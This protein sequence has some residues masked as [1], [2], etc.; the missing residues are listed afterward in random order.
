M[1]NNSKKRER[2][3]QWIQYMQTNNSSLEKFKRA[4]GA[5]ML[6]DISKPHKILTIH[7]ELQINEGHSKNPYYRK[8]DTSAVLFVPLLPGHCVIG[9]FGELYIYL[10]IQSNNEYL[11]Y[12]WKIY[13]NVEMT[14][15]IHEETNPDFFT[16][17]KK[18]I[19]WL[20]N[21]S[22]PDIL[23]FGNPDII[24][25]LQSK[26]TATMQKKGEK[27][28]AKARNS[29]I[30]SQDPIICQGIEIK[31]TGVNLS[32]EA[33]L[34][35]AIDYESSKKSSDA[36]RKRFKRAKANLEYAKNFKYNQYE[37][38]NKELLED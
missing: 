15:I 16:S 2:I 17:M 23:G 36:L 29:S 35:L 32:S 37:K 28:I 12:H 25:D 18:Y 4:N 27:L 21:L 13:N 20:G 10:E 22:I 34:A 31:E 14:Q 5:Y 3:P 6:R 24:H 8:K 1:E 19:N 30:I 7:A 33:T 9:K 11:T 26:L 38:K